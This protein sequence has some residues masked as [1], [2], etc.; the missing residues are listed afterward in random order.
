MPQQKT[1]ISCVFDVFVP[2]RYVSHVFFPFQMDRVC[3]T[4][5]CPQDLFGGVGAPCSSSLAGP[6]R[7]DQIFIQEII[8]NPWQALQWFP[9]TIMEVENESLQ[10]ASFRNNRSIFHSIILGG[11]MP[12][13]YLW[14]LLSDCSWGCLK[15][16]FISIPTPM[17]AQHCT[18][19]P[20]K[21]IPR[22][23]MQS[24]NENECLVAREMPTRMLQMK[25]LK[26]A[27]R[28][29]YWSGNQSLLLG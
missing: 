27:T 14:C 29:K 28:K 12:F 5:S 13:V 20:A 15:P 10:N 11:R 4:T 1:H 21:C 25:H 17:V 2:W 9:P 22:G 16:L 7:L 24:Y 3:K 8:R 6:E 18:T 23:A 19:T 26:V